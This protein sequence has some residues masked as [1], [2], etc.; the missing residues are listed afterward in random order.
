MK[1]IELHEAVNKK[2]EE[3]CKLLHDAKDKHKLS[4]SDLTESCIIN[5]A[6]WGGYNHYESLGILEEAKLKYRQASIDLIEEEIFKE[7]HF[8]VAIK[9]K[10]FLH[11]KLN[12]LVCASTLDEPSNLDCRTRL[13][14]DY[15]VHNDI[16]P[17]IGD[18]ED[19][20]V[21]EV[22]KRKDGNEIWSVCQLD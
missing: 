17:I 15:L 11:M 9:I 8:P 7:E 12:F 10:D 20:V 3:V 13:F 22:T 19:W 5:L 21:T 4:V 6:N 1:A 18:V 16:D 14:Q 2:M